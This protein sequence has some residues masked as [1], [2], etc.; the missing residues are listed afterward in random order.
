MLQE[1]KKNVEAMPHQKANVAECATPQ[2]RPQKQV[3]ADVRSTAKKAKVQGALVLP[4]RLPDPKRGPQPGPA[5]KLGCSK[6]RRSAQ[7]C[8]R[9]CPLKH[10]RYV[11]K[12]IL[13]KQ[14]ELDRQE[15]NNLYRQV[16]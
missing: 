14:E 1:A 10:A 13:K 3:P 11:Q 16:G 5:Q 7:G 8:L 4:V 9:C 15:G 12:K 2:K 6:C